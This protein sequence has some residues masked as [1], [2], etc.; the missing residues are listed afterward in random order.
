MNETNNESVVEPVE[1]T[2]VEVVVD[3]VET[4]PVVESEVD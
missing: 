4:V 3:P 2:V 1:E